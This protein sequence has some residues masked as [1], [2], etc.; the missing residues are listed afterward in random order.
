MP[1]LTISTI[2][3]KQKIGNRTTNAPVNIQKKGCKVTGDGTHGIA[4]Q[5]PIAIIVA[6]SERYT[7]DFVVLTYTIDCKPLILS[8]LHSILKETRIFAD[9]GFKSITIKH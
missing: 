8:S 5:A 2:L 3:P 9:S 1:K 6:N 4:I 7:I